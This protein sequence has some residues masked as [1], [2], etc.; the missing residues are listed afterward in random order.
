MGMFSHSKQTNVNHFVSKGRK[1][2]T[3]T[4]FINSIF[5]GCFFDLIILFLGFL[6]EYSSR[7]TFQFEINI[8]ISTCDY[9][10]IEIK[11][12]KKQ[13]SR[14]Q[15][16]NSKINFEPTLR[17][18]WKHSFALSGNSNVSSLARVIITSARMWRNRRIIWRKYQRSDLRMNDSTIFKYIALQQTNERYNIAINEIN[19][20]NQWPHHQTSFKYQRRFSSLIFR[21]KNISWRIFNQII[22]CFSRDFLSNWMS[23]HVLS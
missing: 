20:S 5:F 11:R 21:W 6:I 17:F 14:W 15:T 10:K 16:W 22:D 19:Q 4:E 23:P 7:W 1:F 12:L 9:L 18:S 8:I 13:I 2:I 3:K